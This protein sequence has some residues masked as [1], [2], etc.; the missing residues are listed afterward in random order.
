MHNRIEREFKFERPVLSRD[1]YHMLG[2]IADATNSRWQIYFNRTVAYDAALEFRG[3]D[4]IAENAKGSIE[5]GNLQLGLSAKAEKFLDETPPDPLENYFIGLTI[6]E[7]YGWRGGS[8]SIQDK[9]ELSTYLNEIVDALAR[10]SMF[11]V[12]E[13]QT[14]ED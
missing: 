11:K 3:P 2:N 9:I 1:L 7:M 4:L 5:R 13:T 12:A 14:T 10:Y 6:D 8:P